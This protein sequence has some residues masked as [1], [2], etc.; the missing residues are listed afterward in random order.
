M[1]E[2]WKDIPGLSDS[3]QASNLGRIKSKART[4]TVTGFGAKNVT[5]SYDIPEKI[6]KQSVRS[7]YYGITLCENGKHISCIVHR[8]IAKTFLPDYSEELEVNHKNENKLDNMLS[9]LEMCTRKYNKNYGT[10]SIRSGAKRSKPIEQLDKEG[11]TI[12]EWPSINAASRA[13]NISIK[14]I[15]ASCN[16]LHRPTTCKY[17][18]RYKYDK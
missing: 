2:I 8:L 9:N 7:N 10:G 4:I 17:V 5:Y 3:Y 14:D 1:I 16:K 18:W 11:R 15:W 12:A 6:M 13:T